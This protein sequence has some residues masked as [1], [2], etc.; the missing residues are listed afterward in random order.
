LR[1]AITVLALGVLAV[2]IFP[3]AAFPQGKKGEDA[4]LRSV[5]GVVEGP[6][7]NLVE[8]AVVQLKN[9]KTLQVRSFITQ[10][11]GAYSFHGLSPDVDYELK[12]EYKELS[13]PVRRLS[14]YDTRK[15]VVL[16]LKLEAKP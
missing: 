12:A 14:V 15:K 8:G 7:G 11:D 1:H 9:T 13:S 16:D 2:A 3:F 6:R 4:N 10:H 5:Q